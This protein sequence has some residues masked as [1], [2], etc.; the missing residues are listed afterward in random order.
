VSHVRRG[1]LVDVLDHGAVGD[2][3]TD[4]TAAIQAA[5][6]RGGVTFLPPGDYSCRTLTLRRG[7]HLVGSNS[8]TYTYRRNEYLADYAPGTVSRIVRRPSTNGPLLLGPVGAKRVIV[9]DLQMDGNNARQDDDEAPVV[10]L[11]DSPDAEDTQWVLSRCYVHGRSDPRAAHWGRAASNIYIGAG[12]MAC[13]LTDTVSNHANR[14]GLE[15]NGADTVVD[16]CIMGDNGAHGIVIG[17]WV[18]AVNLCAIYN[19]EDGIHITATGAGSPK[20][21]LLTGNGIDRNR[22]HGILVDGGQ[23]SGAAGVSVMNNLFTTNST[24]ADGGASHV[25]VLTTSG[26]VALG[27]NVFSI[28]EPGHRHRTAAAVHLAE[29]AAAL[30]MGNV[31]EGGS[32]L[33]FTNTPGGLYTRTRSGVSRDDDAASQRG[34][35][36]V[37]H[38]GVRP[39]ARAD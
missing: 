13:H 24:R 11:T 39:A 1:S 27:G 4:D 35:P 17:A 28:L 7:S 12:R 37:V 18:A 29:G 22:R 6:D 9:E 14:H 26:H 3:R 31:Y 32:V 16:R 19:N 34:G 38:D 25:A 15:V 10:E 21:I 30:D 20:R 33:G 36:G 2:G 8:G 5:I 23:G